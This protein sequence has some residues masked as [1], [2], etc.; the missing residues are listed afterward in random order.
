MFSKVDGKVAKGGNEMTNVMEQDS[1]TATSDDVD[2]KSEQEEDTQNLD[3]PQPQMPMGLSVSELETNAAPKEKNK[4]IQNDGN[5]K[6]KASDKPLSP[7]SNRPSTTGAA[8]VG[9]KPR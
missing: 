4:T 8:H 3:L 9:K 2:S 1:V 7:S 6:Q 5:Y